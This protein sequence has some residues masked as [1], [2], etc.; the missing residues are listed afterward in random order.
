[1]L[2]IN[3]A[4][5]NSSIH[6]T[7]SN[8]E[9]FNRGLNIVDNKVNILTD[10]L[11]MISLKN[12]ECGILEHITYSH[13]ENIGQKCDENQ[14]NY[15][16][17]D[18]FL[19]KNVI[20]K[21]A[22]LK[23]ESE[24][25]PIVINVNKIANTADECTQIEIPHSDKECNTNLVLNDYQK[26]DYVLLNGPIFVLKTVL[27]SEDKLV[28][29]D[30]SNNE[31][32][33]NKEIE[34][35][36]PSDEKIEPVEQCDTIPVLQTQLK[37]DYVPSHLQNNFTR[38]LSSDYD[39][40]PQRDSDVSDKYHHLLVDATTSIS[41]INLTRA[42]NNTFTNS[43]ALLLSDKYELIG[44][45]QNEENAIPETDNLKEYSMLKKNDFHFENELCRCSQCEFKSSSTSKE[46]NNYAGI[47]GTIGNKTGTRHHQQMP[48][49]NVSLKSHESSSQS[50]VKGTD[51]KDLSESGEI[52]RAG[53]CTDEE[54]SQTS[55]SR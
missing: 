43:D 4:E 10:N 21:E 19:M 8:K 17:N 53:V 28:I 36:K 13:L 40:M 34:S 52:V 32:D 27:N 38:L 39:L 1:M 18:V 50:I 51:I 16:T 5:E 35:E 30:K 48:E 44:Q 55:T 3:T 26:N 2:V 45:M 54:L 20:N 24:P 9:R 12:T 42:V 7:D 37:L 23:T 15:N 31:K 47:S 22:T 49:L 25:V 33:A 29:Y 14:I 41:N 11:N 6:M 46:V